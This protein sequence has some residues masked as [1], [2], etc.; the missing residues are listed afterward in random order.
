MVALH[1]VSNRN[2][3]TESIELPYVLMNPCKN[4]FFNFSFYK[5]HKLLAYANTIQMI[6]QLYF[7]IIQ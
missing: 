5:K 7:Y 6:T 3:S 2:G 4:T 1:N